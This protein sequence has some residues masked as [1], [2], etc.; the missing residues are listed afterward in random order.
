M[1]KGTPALD[2]KTEKNKF[3]GMLKEET[4][5]YDLQSINTNLNQ[6]LD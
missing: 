2:I 4:K 6:K 3:L 1:A 5:S